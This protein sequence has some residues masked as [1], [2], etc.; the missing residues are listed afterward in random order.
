MTYCSVASPVIKTYVSI[1]LQSYG[2]SFTGGMPDGS[3]GCSY[4]P[5]NVPLVAMLHTVMARLTKWM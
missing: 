1:N 2:N 4:I 5:D 3:V